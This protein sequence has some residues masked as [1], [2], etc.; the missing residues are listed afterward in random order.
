MKGGVLKPLLIASAT[1]GIT[2]TIGDIIQQSLST[3][4]YNGRQT[5]E[6]AFIGA[7]LHGPYFMHGFKVL[8][9]LYG[10]KKTF[11]NVLKKSITGQLL[12]FPPFLVLFLSYKSILEGKDPIVKMKNDIGGIFW[13]G[14]F[15]WPIAN[16]INFGF[17]PPQGR[18]LFS[19]VVGTIWNTYLSHA[20]NK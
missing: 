15:F 8:D 12:I 2:F 6:F 4:S 19:N 13:N 14:C 10:P 7:T 11:T 17:V 20:T 9:Y 3:Y 5:A 16:M 18:L 1:S